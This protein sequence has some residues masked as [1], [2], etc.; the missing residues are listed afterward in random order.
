MTWVRY[1]LYRLRLRRPRRGLDIFRGKQTVRCW[2]GHGVVGPPDADGIRW[3]P[4]CGFGYI[5]Q[6][7]RIYYGRSS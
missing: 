4:K 6:S 3:C 2:A 5:V 1:L 7:W